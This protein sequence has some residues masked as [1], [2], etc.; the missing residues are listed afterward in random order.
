MEKYP[1]IVKQ[2]TII[3]IDDLDLCPFCDSSE[4]NIGGRSSTLVGFE[5]KGFS[6]EDPNH[7]QFNMYCQKCKKVYI[8]HQRRGKI[9]L[10]LQDKKTLIKGMPNC[11]EDIFFNC[12]YCG[13]SCSNSVKRIYTKMDG[14]EEVTT[15]KFD[16]SG[17]KL[18]REF[19]ECE[20]C[21]VREE[22]TSD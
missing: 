12:E 16:G 2:N 6:Y 18:F 1:K 9:W 17:N 22:L 11:F 20:N 15:L 3:T 8:K 10:T 4:L 5:G 7:H 19:Y 14:I 13:N 21:G